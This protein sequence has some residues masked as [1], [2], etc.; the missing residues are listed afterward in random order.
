MHRQG[1]SSGRWIGALYGWMEAGGFTRAAN[2][3]R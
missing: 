1:T 3:A 2:V